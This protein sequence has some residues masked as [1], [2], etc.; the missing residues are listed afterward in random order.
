MTDEPTK[1][2]QLLRDMPRLAVGLVLFIVFLNLVVFA[3]SRGETV[4][5]DRFRRSGSLS[6]L[7]WTPP[8]QWTA[9]EWWETVTWKQAPGAA[10]P[11]A[12]RV[13]SYP[14]AVVVSRSVSR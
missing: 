2:R 5:E 13:L 6:D 7:S 10:S 3:Y 8:W 4:G 12:P 14:V 1:L 11:P 9:G